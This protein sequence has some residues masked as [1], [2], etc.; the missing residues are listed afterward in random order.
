VRLEAVAQLVPWVALVVWWFA[1][2]RFRRGRTWLRSPPVVVGLLATTLCADASAVVATSR[3]TPS[4]GHSLATAL[5]W[6]ACLLSITTFLVL[7]TAEDGGD[8][9][10]GPPDEPPEPPWWPEFERAF[11]DYTRRGGG[12]RPGPRPKEPA[13]RS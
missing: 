10:G 7:R 5:L 11:R 12:S 1:V 4:H 9:G 3:M 8:D 13:A 2:L 6:V